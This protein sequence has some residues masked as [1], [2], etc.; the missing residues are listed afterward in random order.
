MKTRFHQTLLFHYCNLYRSYAAVSAGTSV[1]KAAKAA[2]DAGALV[3]DEIVVGIIADRIHE[4]GVGTF[5]KHYFASQNT[6]R[7][8]GMSVQPIE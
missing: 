5:H 8:A 2:M 6:S 1:G 3:T 7:R 4:A